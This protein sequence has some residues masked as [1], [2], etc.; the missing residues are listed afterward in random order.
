MSRSTAM[1]YLT[2]VLSLTTTTLAQTAARAN[3]CCGLMSGKIYCYGGLLFTTATENKVDNVMNVLDITN[4]TD[5]TSDSLQNLWKSVSYIG[6]NVDLTPRT[7]PQCVVISD[8]NRMI[9]NGGYVS[10]TTKLENMSVVY[11]ALQNKWLAHPDYTEDPYGK[12]QVYWGSSSY[13]PGK[14]VAYFGGF[15]EFTNAN[16]TVPYTNTSIF[17]FADG[18]SRTIGY[19]QVSYLNIDNS[20]ASIK[21]HSPWNTPVPLT[22]ASD[23]FSAR[24]QSVF[25]PVNNLLLFM[26][27]EYRNTNPA[28][29][30]AI[31]RPYSYIKTFNTVTNEWSMMNLT[32]DIPTQSRIY[33]TL[34]LLPSTNRH[35]LLYGGEANDA[36][37]QDY[38]AVLNLDTKVW[39]KQTI[40]AP[41]GT[42]L[43]RS[44]HSSVLVNNNTL[45]VMWGIDPN[46]AGT[47]SVLILNTTNPDAITMSN[48]YI[49][50][51]ASNATQ[52]SDGNTVKPVDGN[53][54]SDTYATKGL[55][56]G[57]TA[58][59]AVAIVVV[60]I[61][62]ALVIWFYLRN[63]KKNQQ[64]RKQEHELKKQQ[65]AEYYNT[66]D[67]EPMEVD[68]DQIETKYT[69][70]PAT[71][72][73]TNSERFGAGSDSVAST[74]I[75]N[76]GESNSIAHAVHPDAAEVHRPN[77][78]DSPPQPPRV[79]K[80]D[81]G[82]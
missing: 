50:P 37:V 1:L 28:S 29:Q 33:S 51:N 22:T 52:E 56:S 66:T 43:Q 73:A 27:G 41:A 15:E 82:Y 5:I 69:E 62:G 44:R 21:L 55:S 74:T 57:A 76:G 14:G 13:V 40:D 58:G 63:K 68:W 35:V 79:L 67:V 6:N 2:L 72:L 4:K 31:P 54:S 17:T 77:A 36:V 38:C 18:Q 16:W 61:L 49:D 11:D 60:V 9:V 10:A 25:D 26:G 75:I 65:Q 32:G 45:F 80:P 19:T 81:G 47:S 71:P 42:T 8:Q 30:N 12:R 59:I 23:Q 24:H 64:I 39:T 34:T 70:M 20:G 7:D 3:T 46:K 48:K 78:M 53:T